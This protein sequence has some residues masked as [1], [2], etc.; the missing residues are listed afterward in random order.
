MVCGTATQFKFIIITTP[1]ICGGWLNWTNCYDVDQNKIIIL[2][3]YVRELTPRS[4]LLCMIIVSPCSVCIHYYCV[5]VSPNPSS[6]RA[7]NVSFFIIIIALSFFLENKKTTRH[8]NNNKNIY[9]VTLPPLV[10]FW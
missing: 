8:N 2:L 4:Y 9:D 6:R 5:T 10:S 1:Y 3:L 7:T